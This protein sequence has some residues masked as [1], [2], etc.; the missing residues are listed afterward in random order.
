MRNLRER[1]MAVAG[2]PPAPK[3][4]PQVKSEAFFLRE[5]IVPL[6]ELC[7]IE[8]ATLD[9]I[10]ACD[11][12]FSGKSWDIHR[13]L[14]LDTETTGLS[15]GAGTVAFE[16][17]IGFIDPRGMVIRQYVMRDYS[18]EGPMLEE[19]AALIRRFDVIVSF[20]GKSF[21]LP[22]L[23][24]R[25]VMNR[26]RL[27]LTQMPHLDLLHA[28]RRVYKLRLKRCNL[29]S[30]EEAVLDQHRTDDLPGAQ[31][32]QRY[33]DYIKT[34][35]SALLEDVLRHN[36]DDVK[37]LAALTGHLCAVF[38]DP[39]KLTHM[40]DMLGVG[41]T[42]LRSGRTEKGRR[43]L[44]IV[45]HSSLS[46]QAHMTLALSYKSAREWEE[47][48]EICQTMLSNGTGGVWP[49]IE[50][51]KYYEHIAKDIQKA[52]A[53]AGGALRYVLNTAP[54]HGDDDA[55]LES[56]R[57]RMERLRYKLSKTDCH[58]GGKQK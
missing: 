38:R 48:V 9:E 18:E 12:L 41:K 30:L 57:R 24:S 54:L 40:E 44:R 36:F 14:F 1:L 56:I 55:Q 34:K 2:K 15:G 11:P 10:C 5:N 4:V 43:C 3:N 50:L 26:I 37:S 32:P 31:V 51:A 53:Y 21:D 16:I 52:Y 7:D 49:Y 27:P 8:Q 23:E 35:E 47:A 13:V 33:F 28:V 19:I 45:G 29:A 39:L 20:N 58:T 46:S 22:L 25:M 6:H 42:L 17:G